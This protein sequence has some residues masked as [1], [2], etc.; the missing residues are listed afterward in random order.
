MAWSSNGGG[1]LRG[2]R[3]FLV[4]IG[5]HEPIARTLGAL[6]ADVRAFASLHEAQGEAIPTGNTILVVR[7]V[8][9]DGEGEGERGVE[10]VTLVVQGFG[11]PG[12]LRPAPV[13]ATFTDRFVEVH[14]GDPGA[15]RLCASIVR[16]AGL[17]LRR[18]V[19]LGPDGRGGRIAV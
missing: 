19:R 2:L 11:I 14:R 4:Q 1:A 8:L 18:F 7:L 13:K 3:V 10:P 15:A 6:G 9:A 16:A 5:D 12:I 17:S